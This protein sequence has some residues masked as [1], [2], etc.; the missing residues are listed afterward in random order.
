MTAIHEVVAGGWRLLQLAWR[1]GHARPLSSLGYQPTISRFP[2]E[3]ILSINTA[4]ATTYIDCPFVLLRPSSAPFVCFSFV[5]FL[6]C[7]AFTSLFSR[8]LSR[9]FRSQMRSSYH[10]D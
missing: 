5:C 6:K 10:P 3:R 4:H 1:A 2:P 8:S 9:R 7:G